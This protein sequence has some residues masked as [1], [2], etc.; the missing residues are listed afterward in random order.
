MGLVGHMCIWLRENISIVVFGSYVAEDGVT[1]YVAE[2]GV[3]PYVTE[4]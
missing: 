4:A 1:Q 3:S 2:D